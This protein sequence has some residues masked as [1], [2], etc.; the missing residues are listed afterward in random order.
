V[1]KKICNKK[2]VCV[3]S[4]SLVV[5]EVDEDLVKKLRDFRF[6]K[7]TNNAAIISELNLNETLKLVHML[8]LSH[9]P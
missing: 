2:H 1:K 5:C 4:E 8:T 7:E 9:I 6:R 3:Q